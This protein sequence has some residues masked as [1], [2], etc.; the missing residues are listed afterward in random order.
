M[1]L[2]FQ[3]EEARRIEEVV[4]IQLNKKEENCEELE[5]EIVS[6]RKKLKKKTIESKFENSTEIWDDIINCQ[7]YPFI[8]TGIGYD[9]VVSSLPMPSLATTKEVLF[10]AGGVHIGFLEEQPTIDCVEQIDELHAPHTL[11]IEHVVTNDIVVD[12]S[13]CSTHVSEP[14]H[15]PTSFNQ[16]VKKYIPYHHP[17]HKNQRNG[18]QVFKSL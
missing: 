17:H 7:R 1:N 10:V 11:A 16:R 3:L 12:M 2:K 8:K 5:Y 6:L 18:N 9:V 14:N 4:R 15:A 13:N